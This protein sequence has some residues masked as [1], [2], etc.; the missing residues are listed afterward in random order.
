M[1]ISCDW[2]Q[3]T[4]PTDQEISDIKSGIIAAS[5][6]TGVDKRFIL[7]IMM[8][9]SG[10]CVRVHS[11]DSGQVRNPGL[12]QCHDGQYECTTTPCTTKVIHGMISE[13]STGTA[14]G[15]GLKQ[16]ITKAKNQGATGAQAFYWA[17]RIYNTGSYTAGAD[18]AKVQYGTA[19]YSSDI[20]NR[21][22]GWASKDKSPC[23]K[24]ADARG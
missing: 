13:G 2:L 11:T 17:A 21:L 4:N 22:T 8:Q 14:K 20:A 7:A 9:E 12:M 3:K 18:L 24:K 10:G 19:C 23:D 1:K 16:V 6:D 15:D 5:K